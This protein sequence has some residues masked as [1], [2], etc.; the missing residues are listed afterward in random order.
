VLNA[1]NWGLSGYGVFVL[2]KNGDFASFLLAIFI[3]NVMLYTMC[4]LLQHC[5]YRSNG[6]HLNL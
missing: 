4:V 3:S 5:S 6:Q 2:G 1:A